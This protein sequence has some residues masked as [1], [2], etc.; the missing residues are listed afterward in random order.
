M[1][2]QVQLP[3]PLRGSE[4]VESR[5]APVKKQELETLATGSHSPETSTSR[6][7]LHFSETQVLS[8]YENQNVVPSGS[9]VGP[10]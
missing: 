9:G 7:S 3:E 6:L 2:G 1:R 10:I 8:P 4:Q 5:V